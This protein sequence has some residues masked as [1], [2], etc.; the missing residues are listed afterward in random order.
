MSHSFSASSSSFTGAMSAILDTLMLN[1][2]QFWA[3]LPSYRYEALAE[4]YLADKP[5]LKART[6]AFQQARLNLNQSVYTYMTLKSS[7]DKLL[8]VNQFN[9]DKK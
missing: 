3:M 2:P 6:D 1:C 7:L 4:R 5:V 9:N 8:G